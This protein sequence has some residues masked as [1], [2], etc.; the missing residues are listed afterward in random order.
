MTRPVWTPPNLGEIVY[1]CSC[2]IQMGVEAITTP[3]DVPNQYSADMKVMGDAGDMS[4]EAV[5]GE[6]GP[7]GQATFALRLATDLG[8]PPIGNPVDLPEL[9]DST[10]HIGLYWLMDELDDQGHILAEWCYVWWGSYYRQIMMGV[11]GQPGAM[12]Q[13]EPVITLIPP[14]QPP[15]IDTS[16]SALYPSWE[17][18][19]PA[20]FGPP[21]AVAPLY[22]F[23]DVDE[24]NT[25]A[26][27]LN[28]LAFT[29]D[30][31]ADGAP[32]F[33][34][35]DIEQYLPRTYSV[36]ESA[37]NGFNGVAQQA[38]IGYFEVPA[39][40]FP[41]TPMVWGH[42]G[43]DGFSLSADPLMIGCQVLLNDG[44]SGQ[45]IARGIGSTLGVVNVVPH[46]STA[47]NTNANITPYNQMALIPANT[48]AT[49]FFN[50]WND[51]QLGIYLFT[52][53]DAQMF[54][55]ALPMLRQE[56]QTP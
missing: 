15:K 1:L 36:P 16:G 48:G 24:V 26:E 10:Q 18:M 7:D 27:P 13:V 25:V 55:M 52:P 17:Y 22:G 6:V 39:Q 19:V 30:Y 31:T 4:L 53:T 8:Y 12:P 38:N 35:F 42:V 40:P 54:V 50:L 2:A 44:V 51:G 21:G 11:Q 20:P 5:M 3:P 49:L 33:S 29:G 56:T 23:A 34:P 37:F 9:D 41:W 28:V 47:A 32:Q 14:D 43:G 45:Q 46:Y